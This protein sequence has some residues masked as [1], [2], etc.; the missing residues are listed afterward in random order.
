MKK[1]SPL[2]AA[3]A[4]ALVLFIPVARSADVTVN[5]SSTIAESPTYLF[6]IN[7]WL[8]SDENVAKGT[9]Y[10]NSLG[11]ISPAIIR[12]HH[13]E[14]V[15]PGS[16]YSWVNSNYTWNAARVQTI[17][18]NG[19][20]SA[21]R[22]I[23]IVKWPAS[24]AS[25][26]Q[27]DDSKRSQFASWCADLV[28]I[29]NA[30]GRYVKYWEIFNEVDG[31]YSSSDIWKL[32]EAFKAARTA[33]LAKD[34]TIL[35]GGPAFLHPW[36]NAKMDAFHNTVKSNIDFVSFHSYTSSNTNDTIS[37]LYD[38][39]DRFVSGPQNVRSSMNAKGV[40]S[41]VPLFL[42]E[43]NMYD[44]WNK[45]TQGQMRSNQSAVYDALSY[46]KMAEAKSVQAAFAFN[47]A[48]WT[49]GK[50]SGSTVRASGHLM[51]LARR[52]LGGSIVS[53]QS[54]ASAIVPMAVITP[55]RRSV[56]LIN[57]SNNL[58]YV[59]LNLGGWTPGSTD[60]TEHSLVNNGHST[61]QKTWNGAP[62]NV[63]VAAHSIKILEFVE[64]SASTFFRIKNRWKGNF[65]RDGGSLVTYG[66]GTTD[67]YHWRRVPVSG[68]SYVRWLNRGTG[69]SMHAENSS[70]Q[71]QATPGSAS[72][73]SA[74]WTQESVGS[75]YQIMR[76]RHRNPSA[77]HVEQQNGS[78][79]LGTIA[80]DWH[81]AHWKPEAQ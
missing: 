21:T 72:W 69:D 39:T 50:F 7:Q 40:P 12:Y 35:V 79:Q 30:N 67:D 15:S 68:T 17:I 56:V 44:S 78:A 24:M 55:A 2:I 32:G 76:N 61:S 81:S 70:T 80:N 23:N 38:K 22:L 28:S 26:S 58:E 3:C 74:Q 18:S 10:K 16:P 62:Q 71:V 1:R 27:L 29:V 13:G 31:A 19:P 25:G 54:N 65:L 33:M 48:D 11:T 63:S 6:G 8:G 5:W 57:R 4:A 73:H 45:D 66:V 43:W 9:D 37:Y 51:K 75:S 14:Q 46:K 34:P 36:D 60:W 53:T 42:T 77:I 52:L 49:Y 41:T 47:D 59:N 20:A 64:T